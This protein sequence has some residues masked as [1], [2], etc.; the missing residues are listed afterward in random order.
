MCDS[1]IVY[2]AVTSN[3]DMVFK[4]RVFTKNVQYVLFSDQPGKVKGWSVLPIS[5]VIKGG[6]SLTNR[7]YKLFPHE[8]FID[9][10]YSVYV[11]GN[12][13]IIADLTPLLQEFKESNAAL[14]VFKHQDRNN[15]FQEADACL[16]LGKFDEQDVRRVKKQLKVYIESGMPPDQ[17]LTY[18]G[19]IFR[20]HKHPGLSKAMTSW[21]NQMQ[22]YS[23]R[24]QI[25]L[26]F[27]VWENNL[28]VKKWNMPYKE[29]NAYFEVYPHRKT[30]IRNLITFIHV[31]RNDNKWAGYANRLL[32][33]ARPF[34]KWYKR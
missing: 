19:I 26:P 14:G 9:A 32:N 4:P 33:Y 28:P 22:S 12:I 13:R 24:D 1:T 16:E 27:V 30:L 10:E 11:D 31:H 18:N 21:W 2:S 25:S 3:Y 5:K 7:W 15:V 34:Y 20:W 23:K 8:V 29:D 17:P 6:E